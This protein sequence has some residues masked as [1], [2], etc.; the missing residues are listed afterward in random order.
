MP[1]PGLSKPIP[2]PSEPDPFSP[3]EFAVWRG[4]LRSYEWVTRE[5]DRRLRSEHGLTFD[6]YGVL[7]TLVTEPDGLAI[8]E[9]GE[10][11]NLS[12]SGISRAV[13]RVAREGLVER[14]P[15]PADQRS[16][17]V[18][19]TDTGL[20][21]LRSAQV[22]HH[23]LVR[24]RLLSRLDDQQLEQFAELWEAAVPGSVTSASWPPR[25]TSSS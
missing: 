21:R 3:A 8:G 15:N 6:A 4:L 10:R 19:L 17:V 16:F 24:E 13:D 18:A 23:A 9:L 20:R 2:G 12:P 22:T 14:Q 1:S 5:L 11:R 7:I 25:N